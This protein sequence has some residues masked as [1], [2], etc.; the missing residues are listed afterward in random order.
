MI[1][2][3]FN[4]SGELPGNERELAGGAT[5]FHRGDDV[6][7]MAFV[8][9]GEVRLIRHLA[10]GKPVI[11]QR[12]KAGAMLAE[13]SLFSATYHC[14]AVAVSN[15]R[16]RLVEKPLMLQR[17]QADHEFASSWMRQL[18]TEI[19]D[20]RM[21]SEILSLRTISDRLDA[22]LAWHDAGPPRGSWRQLAEDIG[23]SP[24]ALYREIARRKATS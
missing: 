18:S 1:A 8:L 15:A 24:E 12:A 22:W 20:A 14:D 3:M 17:L 16:V 9:E 2:I 23:V 6:T 5:L 11:L 4:G 13:A 19:R 7:H 10:T 21:R